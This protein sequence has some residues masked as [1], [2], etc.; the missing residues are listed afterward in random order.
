MKIHYSDQSLFKQKGAHS[1][2]VSIEN[3]MEFYKIIKDFDCD[4][5]LETKDKDISAIKCINTVNPVE[6]SKKYDEWAKY[7]Y[8]VM[9][10]DYY[11]YKECS[12]IIKDN[13]SMFEFYKTVDF[14]LSKPFNEGAFKNTLQHVWGYFK[15]KATDKEYLKFHQLYNSNEFIKCKSLLLKLAEKYNEEYILNS[16]YFIY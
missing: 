16:Y 3:F 5:M 1:E 10:R 9:E 14:A 15:D 7:K 4:I 11:L 13:S 2:F 8:A 6:K 12:K